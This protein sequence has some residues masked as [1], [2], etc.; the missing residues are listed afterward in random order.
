MPPVRILVLTVTDTEYRAV[1]G[2]FASTEEWNGSSGDTYE[3]FRS[4]EGDNYEVYI[5]KI[6]EMGNAT[7]AAAATRAVADIQPALA[8]LAGIAGGLKDVELGD[9]VIG[10]EVFQYH[11]GKVIDQSFLSRPTSHR[12]DHRIVAQAR[13]QRLTTD[14]RALCENDLGRHPVVHLGVIVS[15]EQVQA[16]RHS[17]E[18]I[19]I[20]RHYSHALCLEMEGYGFLAALHPFNT[21]QKIVLR[22]ISDLCGGKGATDAEGWQHKALEGLVRFLRLLVKRHASTYSAD[23]PEPRP[24]EIHSIPQGDQR[25][26]AVA[27]A[28]QRL[29]DG[30]AGAA[31]AL[32]QEIYDSDWARLSPRDKAVVLTNLGVHQLERGE[33]E[34]ALERFHDA[35]RIDPDCPEIVSNEAIA[36]LLSG[37]IPE[38]RGIIDSAAPRFPENGQIW[39]TWLR[40]RDWAAISLDVAVGEL[41]EHLRMHPAVAIARIER[42]LV[43]ERLGQAAGLADQ[44][45]AAHPTNLEILSVWVGVQ[46]TL[47]VD[48]SGFTPIRNGREIITARL[49]PIEPILEQALI[50]AR[51]RQRRSIEHELLLRQTGLYNLKANDGA[52]RQAAYAAAALV[53]GFPL[54]RIAEA[55]RLARA[56]KTMEAEVVL[57]EIASLHPEYAAGCA[58]LLL[59]LDQDGNRDPAARILAATLSDTDAPPHARIGAACLLSRTDLTPPDDWPQAQDVYVATYRML[60]AMDEE[61]KEDACEIVTRL[62]IESSGGIPRA[63]RRI[64]AE[65]AYRL[66]DDETAC[67]LFLE[68]DDAAFPY[69]IAQRCLASCAGN[70]DRQDILL[71]LCQRMLESPRFDPELF[72]R[73]ARILNDHNPERGLESA[74]LARDGFPESILP[75]A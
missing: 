75:R 57:R 8:I 63:L 24:P 19:A 20:Q 48:D 64:W 67:S 33:S 5:S 68:L 58:S 32:F 56:G 70:L 42:L 14:F 1:C 35:Y 36:L 59:D 26:P 73:V 25:D 40:L 44:A 12:S 34:T 55:E 16:S 43:E 45:R 65:T 31:Y 66:Q 50:L 4:G 71:A 69:G 23:A 41:P 6:P 54:S 7:A 21:I 13:S 17:H 28:I 39:A 52:S 37:R 3:R 10:T 18:Y 38:G 46:L 51:Q 30:E 62:Y 27:R 9:I 11:S 53:P 49:E 2:A 72:D 74:R 47:I 15:G 60:R 22:A 61:R 29:R